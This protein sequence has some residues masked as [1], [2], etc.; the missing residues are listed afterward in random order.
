MVSLAVWA[1]ILWACFGAGATVLKRL[2]AQAD[3]TAEEMPFATALGMGLLS[4]LVLVAGLLGQLTVRV[5]VALVLFLALLGWREMVGL[6][7]SVGALIR[8]K[9]ARWTVFPLL[10]FLVA[11]AALTVVGALAPS[12]D[13]DY[14]GLVYHLA[15]PKLYLHHG[16]I[17]P[18]PWLSH[19]NFP[20]LLEMLYLLGLLLDG[21]SLAKLFHFGCGWLTACAVFAFTRRWWGPRAGWLGAAVFAS[22]PL[23]AWEM[24]VAYNELAFAMYAFLTVYAL[25]R[26]F[27]QRHADPHRGWLWVAAIMCGLSLGT[28]MLAGAVLLFA[29]AALAWG[30]ERAQGIRSR[31]V[32]VALFAAIAAAVA[33]PWYVKSYL[34]TGNPVYPFCY[35]IFGGRYWSAER[36]GAYSA[37]QAAFGMGKG[38]LAF[39]GLPWNLTMNTR[40]FFDL[41]QELRGINIL[42]W[43]FGPLFLALIPAL[44]LTGPVS[45]PGRLVLWFSLLYVGVWFGLTQ[46][47]RYLIPILPGL[48]ACTGLSADRLLRRELL[49][50]AAVSVALLLAM[51]SGLYASSVLAAPAFRVALGR[52]SPRAYLNRN[53]TLYPI[54]EAVNR[55]TPPDA[56]ILVLGDEPRCFY[57][58]RDYLLGNHA[59]IFS[60][61]DLASPDSLLT[62]LR[63][64]GV[65]HLLLHAS[66]LRDMLVRKGEIESLLGALLDEQALS[67]Q[68][69]HG[70]FL[71]W[72]IADVA[73][74]K[75]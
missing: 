63:R 65:S 8:P 18:I 23:I 50:T 11:S 12:T 46:N 70:P 16:S 51:L 43:V 60:S 48:C 15:I 32:P 1:L 37:A 61:Q 34:W 56:R 6:A 75:S 13:S 40:W 64:A 22:V 31:L 19:A 59:D 73:R 30:M 4:Y 67:P 57:L 44:L 7:Q 69:V 71:L 49:V 29:L 28:K 25:S 58:D 68:S 17:H 54:F 47:G 10:I 2:G 62:A 36:A 21:Q 74:E 72:R 39:V 24:T 38:S 3:T 55:E 35:D 42:L 53:S 14:D 45:A 52:E 33:C 9:S 27:D 5:G 26:W 41:P 20:F 66:S